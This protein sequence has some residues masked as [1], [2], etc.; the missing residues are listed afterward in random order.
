MAD[1]VKQLQIAQID[2][3]FKNFSIVKNLEIPSRGWLHSIRTSMNMSLAQLAR[4]LNKTPASVKEIE[5]REEQKTITL[6]KLMEVGDALDLQLVY[7][8]VPKGTSLRQIIEKRA[9]QIATDIVLK[10]SHSMMLENQENSE[11][12][13]RKAIRE[14]ANQLAQ[15][16]P[17]YL[18]D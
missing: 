2:K 6:K 18:W 9:L 11:E 13:L 17:K 4:R 5:A 14:K 3:K 7:A 8:L 16:L 12:R 1:N 10:T 15:E